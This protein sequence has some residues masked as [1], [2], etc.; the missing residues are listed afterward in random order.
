MRAPA[1]YKSYVSKVSGVFSYASIV[2]KVLSVPSKGGLALYLPFMQVE[3][4]FLLTWA[5]SP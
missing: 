5:G 4:S 1:T 3:R 2:A